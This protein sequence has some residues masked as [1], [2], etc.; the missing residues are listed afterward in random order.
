MVTSFQTLLQP[1]TL[2]LIFLT[3]RFTWR[4]MLN[5]VDMVDMDMVDNVDNMDK[6]DNLKRWKRWTRTG[7]KRWTR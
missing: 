3:S 4:A 7:W 1:G 5:K 2:L 6:V